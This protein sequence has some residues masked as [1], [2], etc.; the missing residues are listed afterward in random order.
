MLE[1]IKN[2]LW[3]RNIVLA[4]SVVILMMVGINL[5]LKVVTRHGEKNKVP[6]FSG[7]TIE[8]ANQ[9]ASNL[10]L[11]LEIVD[12]L[13]VPSQKKGAIL[14]Q[15]PKPGN[16]V[17]SGRHIFLTT[18]TM[19]PKLVPL[20][21]V[22]GFS[23]RQAKNKLIGSG[24]VIDRLIY[25]DDIAT[26]NVLGQ[27]YNDRAV[28]ATSNIMAEMGSGV[29]LTIGHNP[30]DKDPVVPSLIG[31][32]VTEAKNRIW[33]AGFN[34]GSIDLDDDV[35]VATLNDARIYSQYPAKSYSAMYGRGVSMKLTLD[36]DKVAKG[37]K[38]A[39]RQAAIY[40][41]QQEDSLASSATEGADESAIEEFFNSI[42]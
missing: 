22:T 25:K 8:E 16:F 10:K 32:S 38:E 33:E 1:S 21:Y 9:L 12:S 11:Q 26:N 27:S 28:S 40:V 29:T 6:N 14:E 3:V 17:K 37:Q 15:Y 30:V 13:Y 18:N 4:I 39:D 41:K 2:N 7:L 20:P 42:N 35:S 19:T 23:L 24:F 36:A 5:I 34:V 31:L